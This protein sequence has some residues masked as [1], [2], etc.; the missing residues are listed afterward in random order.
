MARYF[1]CVFSLEDMYLY[2]GVAKAHLSQFDEA[3]KDFQMYRECIEDTMQHQTEDEKD[4]PL[5]E[6]NRSCRIDAILNMVLCLACTNVYAEELMTILKTEL[7]K[8]VFDKF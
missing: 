6:R 7:S 3:V 4:D 2:C 8:D 5:V 1:E